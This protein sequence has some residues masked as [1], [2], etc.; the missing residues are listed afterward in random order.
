MNN[1]MGAPQ[2]QK[3]EN[4]LQDPDLVFDKS[5]CFQ[6]FCVSVRRLINLIGAIAALINLALDIVYA[7]KIPYVM[8]MIF[9]ITCIFILLRIIFTFVAGQYYYTKFVRNYRPNMTTTAE[10]KDVDIDDEVAKNSQTLA[11]IKNEGVNLYASLHLL[12]YT[13]FFRMLPSKDFPFEM[14]V[15]YALELF[16]QL[17][18]NLFCQVFNNAET[19]GEIKSIQS[20][21]L[22]MK[23]ICL[24]LMITELSTMIWEI[25]KNRDLRKLKI[26]GYEKISEEQRRKQNNKRMS[27]IGFASM[28]VFIVLIILA[29]MFGKGR[30]C[31]S[32]QAL[33]NAVCTDC[34]SDACLSCPKSSK[35][36]GCE[37]CDVGYTLWQGQCVK[38]DNERYVKCN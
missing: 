4:G 18:P 15:A 10:E 20:G 16:F 6:P 2:I 30:E 7:Y 24:V 12:F 9:I 3:Q 1:L 14:G 29:G 8:K 23:L 37:S 34:Y 27:F 35:L 22:F 21:A 28:F 11:G 19:Q 5:F 25:T 13:G 17:I 33:E 32:K 36:N 31:G 26:K 38:C